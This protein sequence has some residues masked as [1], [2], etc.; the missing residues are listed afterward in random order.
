MLLITSMSRHAPRP[1]SRHLLSPHTWNMTDYC[2]PLEINSENAPLSPTA[3]KKVFLESCSCHLIVS[4][5][6]TEKSKT[7]NPQN[8]S[9]F[10]LAKPSKRLFS[11]LYT[12]SAAAFEICHGITQW[13][14]QV[15][16]AR[17]NPRPPECGS[18]GNPWGHGRNHTQVLIQL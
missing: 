17:H 4:S 13:C 1:S 8:G 2:V 11:I 6:S 10:P 18:Q 3:G 5:F 9:V 12:P 14:Q 7:W 15:A 16:R